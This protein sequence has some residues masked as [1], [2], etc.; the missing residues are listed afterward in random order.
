[1]Q[2]SSLHYL[3]WKEG[4]HYVSQC[5]NVDVS[6]FGDSKEDAIHNLEEALSLYFEDHDAPQ[7]HIEQPE[8][9]TRKDVDE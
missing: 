9:I 5:I 6:S 3:V 4:K 8:I 2:S 1:M 7:T